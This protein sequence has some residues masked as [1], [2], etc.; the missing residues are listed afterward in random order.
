M[1]MRLLAETVSVTTGG[2]ERR[3]KKTA[4]VHIIP[5]SQP[6]FLPPSLLSS[7]RS[8]PSIVDGQLPNGAPATWARRRSWEIYCRRDDTH[9]RG[10]F[11]CI[12]PL[13]PPLIR[14]LQR[15]ITA[16]RLLCLSRGVGERS[17]AGVDTEAFTDRHPPLD[18]ALVDSFKAWTSLADATTPCLHAR[19]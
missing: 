15:H 17:V 16:E 13:D 10:T 8:S 6:R 4:Y 7:L 19:V 11:C 1:L 12:P 14:P 18:I 5:S 9:C 3:I 2:P